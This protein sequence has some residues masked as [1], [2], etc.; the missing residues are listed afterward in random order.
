MSYIRACWGKYPDR[1]RLYLLTAMAAVTIFRLW[2]T[3]AQP[4]AFL[5]GQEDD[6]MVFL[7]H[8]ASIIRGHWL[9]VYTQ[10]TLV[11]GAFYP[12][13]VAGVHFTGIPLLLAQQLLYVFA[14]V[15]FIAAIR[16]LLPN[17]A[18]LAVSY[19]LVLFNPGSYTATAT[20]RVIRD[21]TCASFAFLAVSSMVAIYARVGDRYTTWKPWAVLLGLSLAATLLTRE[22]SAWVLPV[23]IV[24]S[25]LCAVLTFFRLKGKPRVKGLAVLVLPF[26]LVGVCS[27][28]IAGAN[29]YA[30]GN[31]VTNEYADANFINAYSA[32]CRIDGGKWLPNVPVTRAA[33]QEAYAVSPAFRELEPYLE[34]QKMPVFVN[35]DDKETHGTFFTWNLRNAVAA[36]G[37]CKNA[38]TASAYYKRLAMELNAAFDSGKLKAYPKTISIGMLSPWHSAYLTPTVQKTVYAIW[39][40]AT[41]RDCSPYPIISDPMPAGDDIYQAVTNEVG[42]WDKTSDF[43]DT[44]KEPPL[45]QTSGYK[46]YQ[47]AVKFNHQKLTFLNEVTIGYQKVFP[48]LF[49]L[50]C[51]CYIFLTVYLLVGLFRKKKRRFGPHWLVCTGV[52]LTFFLRVLIFAYGFV[53][54][55]VP[56]IP[57][58]MVSAYFQ[59]A[60]FVCFTI[61]TTA[62]LLWKRIKAMRSRALAR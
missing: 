24:A 18:I 56:I 50:A 31:F 1:K 38:A 45:V 6:D 4:I 5:P 20:A 58:Y 8:A 55:E 52:F 7:S 36:A 46:L 53:S 23:I 62:L 42:S 25:L 57:Q 19:C 15:I 26:V 16:R 2:M 33:R 13:F 48:M 12:L 35:A 51:G 39:Y 28:A 47:G 40:D 54:S 41:F 60:F 43:A 49:V 61:G 10:N 14:C 32:L 11:K 29:A 30:Y 44:S 34:G 37:Y 17:R 59:M 3:A 9:G 27:V 22:D 21:F